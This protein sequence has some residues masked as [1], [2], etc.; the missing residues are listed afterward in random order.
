MILN[1]PIGSQSSV[2][3][4][5]VGIKLIPEHLCLFVYKLDFNRRYYKRRRKRSR[6]TIVEY[7]RRN[8]L[9]EARK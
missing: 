6:M 7:T 3:C 4:M 5:Y 9:L 8:P 1:V 2:V